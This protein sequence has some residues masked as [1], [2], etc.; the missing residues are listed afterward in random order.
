[1]KGCD[2]MLKRGLLASAALMAAMPALASAAP[3]AVV[4]RNG[5]SVAVE[6]YA[7]GI[8]RVTIAMDGDLARAAP[9][10]GP[11][12]KADAA[13]WTHTV[14]AKGDVFASGA[15]QLRVNA[16][17]WPNAPT[18]MERYFAPSLPGVSIS[19]AGADGHELTTMNGWDMSPHDVA[20]EHTF[21]VGATFSTTADEHF[22][23]LGQNQRGFADLRGQTIDCR[24]NYDAPEGRAS[25]CP[26]W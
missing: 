4:D 15:M 22:W 8:V 19:F 10:E 14:D 16:Q 2:V 1:M 20:G 25:A 3:L 12:A 18:M 21:K 9:G 13:G 26:S 17:P 7:P 6:P 23:G 24:H 11:N 5:A